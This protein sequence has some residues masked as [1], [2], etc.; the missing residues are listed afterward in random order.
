MVLEE[1]MDAV[2]KLIDEKLRQLGLNYSEASLKIGRNQTYLQQ[3]LKRGVPVELKEN[4]RARL[5]ELIG[6]P[7][8]ELRGPSNPLPKREYEKSNPPVADPPR[9]TFK[10]DGGQNLVDSIK[11]AAQLYVGRDL[12]VFGT[13]QGGR[14]DRIVS[15]HAIDY[16]ARPTA[17]L[18]VEEAY[19]IIVAG[20]LTSPKIENGATV[21]VNPHLPCP[22]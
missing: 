1:V 13:A 2:R 12:P 5:A 14:G 9:A 4:D 19:A 3:F 20:D 8:N 16:I 22:D 10:S 11:P 7:E 17:L 21:L 6:V 18:R 15:D